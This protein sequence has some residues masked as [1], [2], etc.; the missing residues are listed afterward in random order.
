MN[1]LQGY[2]T[3]NFNKDILINEE[4]YQ[5]INT[6]KNID[7]EV[8]IQK[9][10]FTGGGFYLESLLR[11]PTQSIIDLD[12][13]W[14]PIYD[15]KKD[16]LDTN[17]ST[18]INTYDYILNMFFDTVRFRTDTFKHNINYKS[19]TTWNGLVALDIDET[20]TGDYYNLL[21]DM[22]SLCLKN[23]IK[24]IFITARWDPFYK[25]HNGFIKDILKYFINKIKYPIDVWFNPFSNDIHEKKKLKEIGNFKTRQLNM[26]REELML[27]NENC[28]LIDDK[29]INIINAKKK[30]FIYSTQVS[31]GN[32][33]GIDTKVIK[34]INK[35]IDIKSIS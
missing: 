5:N 8:S 34:N 13:D 21:E 12:E 4:D 22:I 23:K 18:V 24:I 11:A 32:K 9:K 30:G 28:I 15:N 1:R 16:F 35:I 6:F 7:W 2:F 25:N 29:E 26:A 19:D 27:K 14:N 31:K 20:I 10:D 3:H 17:L 33:I